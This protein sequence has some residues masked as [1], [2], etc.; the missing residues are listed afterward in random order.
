[1]PRNDTWRRRDAHQGLAEEGR[2]SQARGRATM[3]QVT[4]H[5]DHCG[6][7]ILEGGAIVDVQAGGM[8]RQY[9]EALDLCKECSERFADWLRSG[10]QANH[11]GPGGAIS[12]T[13]VQSPSP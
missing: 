1:M 3:K 4:R 5:C 7:N 2:E 6:Q 13:A 11:S 12:Q 10:H 8:V 9:P